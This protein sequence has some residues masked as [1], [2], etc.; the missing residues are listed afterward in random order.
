MPLD[1]KISVII[2]IYNSAN[3]IRKCL[4]SILQKTKVKIE[5]I[6][7]NDGSTDNSLEILEHYQNN[8]VRLTVISKVNEGPAIARNV[9]INASNGEY[10]MFVDSDDII[11]I[12]S[13][14]YI[15]SLIRLESL[16]LYYFQHQK[17]SNSSPLV[18]SNKRNYSL[19]VA[20]GLDYIKNNISTGFNWDKV[21][22]RNFY[23]E[24]KIKVEKGFYFEDQIPTL[25]GFLEADKCGICNYDFYGYRKSDNSITNSKISENHVNS[26]I[27]TLD[28]YLTICFDKKVFLYKHPIRKISTMYITIVRYQNLVRGHYNKNLVRC[29][30]NRLSYIKSQHQGGIVHF[31]KEY[32]IVST[33]AFYLPV[34]IIKFIAYVVK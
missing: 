31:Y 13:I 7:V 8:D 5:V 1:I 33:V 26:L 6:A 32:G 11:R 19:I 14:D 18:F 4:D 16:E 23:I 28:E 12:G 3:H 22:Q 15:Y 20:C 27:Y 21:W 10:L 25:K 29:I 24:K 9:G 2:P 17:F 34:R 30:S